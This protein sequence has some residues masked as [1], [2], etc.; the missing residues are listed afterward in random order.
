MGHLV[1]EYLDHYKMDYTKSVYVPEI[2]LDKASD[3]RLSQ[4]KADL[5]RRVPSL[6]ESQQDAGE[7]VLV[8]MVRLLRNQQS[9]IAHLQMQ[10]E[11]AQLSTQINHA[12]VAREKN[13]SAQSSN[14]QPSRDGTPSPL[15]QQQQ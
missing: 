5:I 9:Q 11:K 10:L 14:S 6:G 4:T 8:Q 1:R 3:L 2:A 15:M 13:N 12:V 7:S